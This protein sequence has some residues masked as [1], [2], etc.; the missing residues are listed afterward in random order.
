MELRAPGDAA[1][2]GREQRDREGLAPLGDDCFAVKVESHGI[3]RRTNA[4]EHRA[5]SYHARTPG[6]NR[7]D[8]LAG[9][10]VATNLTLPC[11]LAV[12]SCYAALVRLGV[13]GPAFG[14]L[15]GLARAAQLLLDQF[16]AERVIYLGID[17]ALDRVVGAWASDLVGANPSDVVLFERAAHACAKAQPEQISAFVS[18]ERAR[19]RLRVFSSLPPSPGRTIELLDG[20]VAV[21]LYD[22]ANLDEDDIAGASL[23]IFGKSSSKL[24]KRVGARTFVAPGKIGSEGGG[25][26]MLDDESGGVRVR[27]VDASGQ[28]SHTE[29]VGGIAAAAK[30]KV[31]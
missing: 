4:L 12:E 2:A 26:A 24:L 7:S 22:K 23:L 30:L 15:S 29:V 31:Q 1:L 14:D 19:R 28:V 25:S 27:I 18:S 5:L 16:S 17:D 9:V 10:E 20:R 8:D 11:P 21:L 13:L 3:R 6:P